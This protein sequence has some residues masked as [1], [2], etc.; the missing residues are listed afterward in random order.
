MG[1]SH[2][3][4]FGFPTYNPWVCFSISFDLQ[5]AVFSKTSL[6]NFDHEVPWRRSYSNSYSKVFNPR[7]FD[8]MPR[9]GASSCCVYL[10]YAITYLYFN[11]LILFI[12]N[13]YF[14][15]PQYFRTFGCYV[16]DTY[17]ECLALVSRGDLKLLSLS[18]SW[19]M[20]NVLLFSLLS[21]VYEV[22]IFYQISPLRFKIYQITS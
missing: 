13:F 18:Y 15:S 21:P 9:P 2:V 3:L 8:Q 19:S 16:Y 5:V 6:Q 7:S 12:L 10:F 4:P 20:C 22:Y 11:Y 14:F 17:W 1:V